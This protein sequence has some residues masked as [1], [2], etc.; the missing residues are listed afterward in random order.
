MGVT[1][2]HTE[3]KKGKDNTVIIFTFA[4]DVKLIPIYLLAWLIILQA[5]SKT[6]IIV[7]FKINQ[8][9]IAQTLCL[10]KE[11]KNNSCQGQ[12]HLKKQLEKAEEKEQQQAPTSQ[13]EKYEVLYCH[14]LPSHHFLTHAGIDLSRLISAYPQS[15]HAVSFLSDIFRPPQIHVM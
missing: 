10:K 11:I 14:T 8:D 13:K 9:L 12:C 4:T 2:K 15:F 1:Q 3:I 5:F 7:S 6:G